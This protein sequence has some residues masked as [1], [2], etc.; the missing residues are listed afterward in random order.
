MSDTIQEPTADILDKA[1]TAL[2]T[3]PISDSPSP[4]L[5]A[6]VIVA[7]ESQNASL[8]VG[9][10]HHKVLLVRAMRYGSLAAIVLLAVAAALIWSDRAATSTF[11]QVIDNTKKA[12]SVIFN[13]KAT[14]SSSAPERRTKL[15]S[16]GKS[17]LQGHLERTESRT[18]Q[19]GF[20]G[21]YRPS[22]SISIS[23]WRTKQELVL[24][25]AAKTAGWLDIDKIATEYKNPIEAIS[26]LVDNDAELVGDEELNGRKTRMFKL[27]R[28]DFLFGHKANNAQEGEGKLWVDSKTNLPVK[29]TAET[30]L[31][32]DGKKLSVVFDNFVWNQPIDPKLFEMKVPDGFD[33]IEAK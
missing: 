14:V 15:L 3:A 17:Y 10:H 16:E 12:T 11:A 7:L 32:V 24:N 25:P 22:E 9:Q 31:G 2:R 28:T 18:D 29:L 13:G 21:P 1:T 33:V 27:L 19:N 23:D 20:D 26:T 4:G 6:A 5:V 30:T 8:V